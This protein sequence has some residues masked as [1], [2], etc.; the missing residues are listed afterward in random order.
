MVEAG[1]QDFS[2]FVVQ[3][4]RLDH[5]MLA[6]QLE[7]EATLRLVRAGLKLKFEALESRVLV[8]GVRQSFAENG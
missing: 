1:M 8:S 6:Y 7:D 3:A 5:A 4:V 2:A